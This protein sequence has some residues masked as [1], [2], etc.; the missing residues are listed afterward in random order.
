MG[1][2]GHTHH[3]FCEFIVKALVPQLHHQA[4]SKIKFAYFRLTMRFFLNSLLNL[5]KTK[6]DQSGITKSFHESLSKKKNHN[7]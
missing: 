6:I 5:T 3:Q 7:V 1:P 4:L 2:V